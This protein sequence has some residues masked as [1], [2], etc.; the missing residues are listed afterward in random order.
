MFSQSLRSIMADHN[1]NQK[2][3]S[4]ELTRSLKP[5]NVRY[6]PATVC[7]WLANKRAPGIERMIWLYEHAEKGGVAWKVAQAAIDEDVERRR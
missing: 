1:M 3:L 5:I 6:S 2:Q 7:F 4:D